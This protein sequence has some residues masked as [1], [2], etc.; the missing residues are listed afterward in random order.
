[1]KFEDFEKQ[2]IQ[3]VP[4]DLRNISTDQWAAAVYSTLT[5]VI[6][7]YDTD[8]AFTPQQVIHTLSKLLA[9]APAAVGTDGLSVLVTLAKQ[10]GVDLTAPAPQS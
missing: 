6:A 8:Q 10:A 3:S 4:E 7:N 5:M 9:T 2:Y 1:M